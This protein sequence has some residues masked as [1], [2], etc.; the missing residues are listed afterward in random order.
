MRDAT[1]YPG[2]PGLPDAQRA[3]STF[4]YAPVPFNPD[5]PT[6]GD[7]IE[8]FANE[9]RWIAACPDCSSAQL[10]AQSDRR[11]MCGE[12]ANVV[13]GGAWRPVRQPNILVR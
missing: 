5:A 8:A 10:T 13:N 1:H 4:W 6:I 9:G 11:F 3:P 7:P 12:C 2:P